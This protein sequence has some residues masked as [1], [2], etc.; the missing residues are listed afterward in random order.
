MRRIRPEPQHVWP[1]IVPARIRERLR[2]R[3]QTQIQLRD[4]Q[5]LLSRGFHLGNETA[6]G[7]NDGGATRDGRAHDGHAFG[8][9]GGDAGGGQGGGAVEDEGLRFDGVGLGEVQAA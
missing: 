5:F 8:L 6:V 4:D 2:L 7:R 9:H 3:D 1:A